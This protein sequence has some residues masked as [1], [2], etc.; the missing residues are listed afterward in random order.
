[1]TAPADKTAWRSRLRAARQA[2]PADRLAAAAAA[3]RSGLL[4]RLAG[5]RA[6]AAYVPVGAE[7]GSLDLLDDL[8]ANGTTVLL[9]VVLDAAELD[10]AEYA[11]RAE[12][13][14]GARGTRQPAG[15]TLGAAALASADLVLVP[16]LGA[17]HQGTRLG[18]GAGYY[19]RA[20]ART[21]TEV[22]VAALLHDGELVPQLPRD[23]WDRQVTAISSPALGWTELPLVPHHVRWA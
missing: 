4:P 12:L 11:G 23:P 22:P 13:V 15:R 5:L 16:A 21:P 8:L 10:W 3:L 6:V 19:D 1:M 18:R 7:P 17:D 20:L 9:P 14:A 2:L